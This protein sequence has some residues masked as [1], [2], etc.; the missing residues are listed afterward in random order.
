MNLDS[1]A[2]KYHFFKRVNAY[3]IVNGKRAQIKAMFVKDIKVVLTA[4]YESSFCAISVE[5]ISS[6]YINNNLE[7]DADLEKLFVMGGKLE[8]FLGYH[9]D[10]TTSLVFTGYITSVCF[11][12]TDSNRVMYAV[13]AMDVKVFMMN[14]YRSQLKKDLKRYSDAVDNVLQDYVSVYDTC[15]IKQSPEVAGPIEQHNQSDYDFVVD[16]AKRLNYLFFVVKDK[17]RFITYD[18][19]KEDGLEVSPSVYLRSFAREISINSQIK[20]VT[21]RAHDETDINQ[22]IEETVVK[23]SETIGG[24]SK[25]AGDLSKL[26]GDKQSILIID[27]T[28]KSRA[29]AKDRAVAELTRQNLPLVSGEMEIVGIPD[30]FPATMITVKEMGAKVNGK[31]FVTEVEHRLNDNNFQTWCKFISNKE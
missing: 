18:A 27:N 21:V 9:D 25:T 1:L 8:L 5:D 6:C 16:I 13:E 3:I 29:E 12:L 11:E 15:E 2:N 24:G 19:V 4:G 20:S 28:I 22:P 31:Y 26:I 14:S 23:I 10:Q 17:V 7:L 30:I